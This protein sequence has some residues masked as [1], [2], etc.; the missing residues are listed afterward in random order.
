VERGLQVPSGKTGSLLYYVSSPAVWNGSS[1]QGTYRL[2]FQ[3][4]PTIN[5]MRL[6]IDIQAPEGT[7]IVWTNVPMEVSD[8]RARWS[9]VAPTSETFEIRFQKSLIPRLWDSVVDFFGQPI[10]GFARIEP[11][12]GLD[13]S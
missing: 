6:S 10:V 2:T 7:K 1:G 12:L 5:P 13:Y 3:S 9:G 4:Q 8:N 11:S